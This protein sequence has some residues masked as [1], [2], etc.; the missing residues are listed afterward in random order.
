MFRMALIQRKKAQIQRK[1]A[2][3]QRKN[4]VKSKIPDYDAVVAVDDGGVVDVP[5]DVANVANVAHGGG[6]VADARCQ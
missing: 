1:K 2:Q 5:S 3:F 4:C 6:R